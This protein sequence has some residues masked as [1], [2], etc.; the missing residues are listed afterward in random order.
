MMHSR[1]IVVVGG[2][3]AGT[4]VMRQLAKELPAGWRAVLLSEET[5]MLYTPLLPEVVGGSLLPTHTVA[6]LRHIIKKLDYRRGVVTGID[7]ANR[8]IQY[9]ERV[10]RELP[11]EH[12]VLACGTLANLDIVPGMAEHGIA[13]KTLGDALY[14]RNRMIERLEQAALEDDRQTRRSLTRFCVIGGGSSGVEVAGAMRDFL[15]AAGRQYDNIDIE[16][17]EVILIESGE[18]LLSEFPVTLGD[19]ARHA[20]ENHGVQ[21]RLNTR[22][23]RV[24]AIAL[25]DRD[26]NRVE[27]RN[28]VCT[29]GTSPCP[30]IERLSLPKKQGRVSTRP[31]MTV[32]GMRNIWAVGDCA[33]VP[34][35]ITGELSPPTAQFAVRHGE[36][37]AKN[38]VRRL[39][40][41]ATRSFSYRP[42]GELACVGYH[43][44]VASIFGMKLSGFPAWLLWRAFYLFKLPTLLRKLQVNFEWNVEMLFPQDVTQLHFVRTQ[45]RHR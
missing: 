16:E 39:Q 28:A 14:L 41:R 5:Y 4:A 40:G 26:G 1:N 45:S 6:P 44:A 22:I 21:V 15:V 37:A 25:E 27:S 17:L 12:L 30:L 13:L 29:I 23:D 42:R 20:L 36:Q 19:F 32:Q 3:F 24:S 18:R 31:E 8:R 34:N 11:Y 9:R 33:A 10:V 35:R 7:F 43:R 38:I 2:G